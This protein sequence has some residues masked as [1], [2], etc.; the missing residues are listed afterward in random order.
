MQRKLTAILS[1]DVVGYSGMM[2]ADEAGT[3][4]R[5]KANRTRIFDPRVAIHGGR[6]FK[7]MGD[8]ALVEFSSVIAAVQCA[9]EIQEATEKAQGDAAKPI[10]YR[11]GINLG[12]VIVEGDDIYGEGVNVAARIQALA[13]IGGVAIARIVRDQVDGKGP[14]AFDDMG[15]HTVKNIERPVHVFSV[16][17]AAPNDA[18]ERKA[19]APGKLSICVLP[20]ANM[21]GDAEQEYFSDG[22]SEDIITDLSKVSALRV[23][24]RNTAFTFKGKHV[25]M[26]QVARQLKVTH[27][28]EGSVRKSGGRVR[29]TAQLIDGAA[30]GHVWAERYDR[31]L[32]DIFAL[33]DEISQAIVAALKLKLLPEEKKA[34]EH[35][36]TDNV[37]AYNLYL[38][39]RQYSVIASLGD[40][41]MAESIM[42]LCRRAIE[43]D[44]NY[45][46]AWALIAV[47]QVNLRFY[48]GL[49][50]KDGLEEA[51][52][53]IALDP[54]LAEAHA[55][56]A[57]V[58]T[59]NAQH[60]AAI[61]EIEKAL[62]LDPE[63]YEVNKA[64][65]RLYYTMRNH[66]AAILHFE[67]AA[68]AMDTDYW[69][70]GMLN[71]CY[72]QSG[73]PEA[74]RR[75]AERTLARTEKIM[76]QDPNNGSA[77]GFAIDALS[78][79]GQGE[80]AK[81]LMN[82]ALLLDPGNMNLRY[83]MACTLIVDL[84]DVDAALDLLEPL[85]REVSRPL[86]NWSASDAD[87]DSIRNHPRYI[88][89]VA[90]AE[91]RLSKDA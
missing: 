23:I 75:A 40:A 86:L 37:E 76:A 12:E 69:A 32:N 7:L 3:L 43:I 8:G 19:D 36:G 21:S 67:K 4:E 62:R 11:I 5:L 38:M 14:F 64:A 16:R 49:E 27:I 53:A 77:M 46:R 54:N 74:A 26:P 55:A 15:E 78:K 84:H 87:L 20:F 73:D 9:L 72:T 68:S 50:S 22:I 59:F 65:A 17:L 58:L 61:V 33:Q 30:D 29:I 10:R 6:Q 89:M 35:R 82:R 2:E 51:E 70:S 71:H 56:K 18:V 48:M 25:D 60:D 80:R 88:A 47:T 85:Y 66:E 83:N 1:A 28:L 90:A 41:R 57:V 34:I 63:S 13:P 42:R 24:S 91:A 45:A 81:N 39:A 31:D 52:R 79:L 44:P